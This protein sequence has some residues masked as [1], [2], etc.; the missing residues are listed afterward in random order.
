MEGVMVKV[1]GYWKWRVCQWPAMGREERV[2]L[3]QLFTEQRMFETLVVEKGRTKEQKKYSGIAMW[4]WEFRDESPWVCS[5]PRRTSPEASS[6][7]CV[8]IKRSSDPDRGCLESCQEGLVNSMFCCGIIF[9]YI[10]KICLCQD[11]F[12]LV[13]KEL[14]SQ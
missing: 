13:N 6:Y 9:L 4:C 12:W 7:F 8:S 10:V 14:N 11:T 5:K 3:L 2:R 1:R